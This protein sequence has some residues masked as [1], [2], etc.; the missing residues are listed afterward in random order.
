MSENSKIK[1]QKSKS[2]CKIPKCLTIF[3]FWFAIL[4]FNIGILIYNCCAQSL[5]SQELINHAKQYDGQMVV[6]SGEAVGDL[7]RR[8]EFCWLNLNDG[9]NAVGVWLALAMAKADRKSVV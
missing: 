7:M 6:Y 1:M 5:S 4:I 8:G 3:T 9:Q 2:Q